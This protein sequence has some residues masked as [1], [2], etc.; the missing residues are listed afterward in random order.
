MWRDL[1]SEA[2]IGHRVVPR[3]AAGGGPVWSA[4]FTPATALCFTRTGSDHRY[5]FR[6]RERRRVDAPPPGVRSGPP[7]HR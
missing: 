4:R 6:T 1:L 2:L 7:G 5:R 3:F